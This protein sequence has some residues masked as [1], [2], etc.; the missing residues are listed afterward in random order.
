VGLSRPPRGYFAEPKFFTPCSECG[1]Q[2]DWCHG[3]P[4]RKVVRPDG[5][6]VCFP[7]QDVGRGSKKE[8]VPNDTSL[9]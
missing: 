9:D 1:E 3:D 2:T 6:V 5:R 4:V 7:C 8:V